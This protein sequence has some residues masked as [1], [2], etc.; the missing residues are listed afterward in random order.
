M[1]TA[2]LPISFHMTPTQAR[3]LVTYIQS[4]RRLAWE[5]TVPSA[6][7]NATLRLLQA[8]QGKLLSTI[9]QQ[10]TTIT[11]MLTINT[12]ELLALNIMVDALRKFYASNPMIGERNT[13]IA[14]LNGLKTSL[15]RSQ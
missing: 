7:R 2:P 11:I 4:Y 5:N 15:E 3:K 9:D 10:N 14:D 12:D 13:I 8:V 1:N 6:E